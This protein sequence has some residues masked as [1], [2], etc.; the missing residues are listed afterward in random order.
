M[1][2]NNAFHDGPI[3]LSE[4]DADRPEM[5]AVIIPTIK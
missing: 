5:H 3:G 2:L 4:G 1:Y